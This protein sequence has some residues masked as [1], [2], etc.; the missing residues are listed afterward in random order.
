MQKKI[1]SLGSCIVICCAVILLLLCSAQAEETSPVPSN[2]VVFLLDASNSMNANDREGLAKDSIAQLIYSLPSNYTVGFAAYNNDVVSSVGMLDN[3]GRAAIMQ[4]A[5]AVQYTG[6]TNAGAGLSRA[7]ELLDATEARKKNVVIL[8]DGEILMG[9]NGATET[10]LNR[11]RSSVSKAREQGVRIHVIGLGTEMQDDGATIF[12]ASTE[13][14][15][16]KY[17]APKA[18]DI[19]TAVDAI[20]Q[21][22]LGVRK[23]RAAIIDMDGGTEEITISLPSSGITMSRILLT[24][25]A[26]LQNVNADFSA[27]DARQYSGAR[28]TLLE[29]NRPTAET[30]HITF[31]GQSGSQ[32]KVDVITEYA[33]MAACSVAYIDTKPTDGSANVYDREAD[34]CVTFHDVEHPERRVLTDAVFQGVS[35]PIT[36]NGMGET[37]VLRDGELHI[38]RTVL[39]DEELLLAFDFSKLDANVIL[40]EPMTVSLD[41]PPTLPKSGKYIVLGLVLCIAIAAVIVWFFHRRKYTPQTVKA[42]P[43]M[44]P[45]K[46]DYTG[47]LNLYVTRTRSGEDIPPLTYNLF[48]IPGGHSLTLGEILDNC[49]VEEPFEGAEKIMFRPAANRCLLLTNDSDCTLLQNREILMKGRSYQVMLNSKVDITFEDEQS[50]MVV[51]YR[52]VKPLG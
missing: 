49:G 32:V 27:S 31:R 21:E 5:A 30:V 14:G 9:D 1:K 4:T 51:Q 45:S 19:Q 13:T 6:Y 43:E 38:K 3:T 37:G 39:E 17:H 22:Q 26:P 15:G 29:L 16:G 48:P 25:N 24:A 2:A 46:F 34:I 42:P 40:E 47:R 11:F 33:V 52:D 23:T 10:S 50:E 12:S 41:A 28:Y 35:I 7:L 44:A 20:L 8:S 36:F 18:V